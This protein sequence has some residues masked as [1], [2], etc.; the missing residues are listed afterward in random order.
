MPLET[1]CKRARPLDGELTSV[2]ALLSHI[3]LGAPAS[4]ACFGLALIT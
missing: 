3:N 1:V 2:C 4:A